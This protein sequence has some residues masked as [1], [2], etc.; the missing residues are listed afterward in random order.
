MSSV[1]CIVFIGGGNM[2][3]AI[4]S[5]LLKTGHPTTHIRVSEPFDQRQEYL[6]KTYSVDVFGS[7]DQ[8]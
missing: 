3:E 2:C 8:A 5:G 7:N 6:R 4:V 1:P